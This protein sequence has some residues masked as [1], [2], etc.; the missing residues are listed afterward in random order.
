MAK[1]PIPVPISPD[2]DQETGIGCFRDEKEW[3]ID[4]SDAVF[5]RLLLSKGWKPQDASKEGYWRF[6][7]PRNGLTIRSR[8]SVARKRPGN[9]AALAAAAARRAAE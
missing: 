1:N 5:V 6:K 4:T 8:A 7:V 3:R 9:A 2:T